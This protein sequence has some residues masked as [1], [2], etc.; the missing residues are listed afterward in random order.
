MEYCPYN[1]PDIARLLVRRYFSWKTKRMMMM[2]NKSW[3]DFIRHK[4]CIV[5]N[6]IY[7]CKRHYY[8]CNVCI[9]YGCKNE[10]AY[11]CAWCKLQYCKHM[12]IKKCDVCGWKDK[13]ESYCMMCHKCGTNAVQMRK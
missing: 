13:N 12:K 2:V 4:S 5:K 8:H 6:R 7:L 1:F 3:F 11:K 10:V 9:R